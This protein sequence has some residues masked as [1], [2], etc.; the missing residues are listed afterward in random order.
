M[1]MMMND[2]TDH[3]TNAATDDNNNDN[4]TQMTHHQQ[5]L[6]TQTQLENI[7]QEIKSTQPLTS[8]LLPIHVLLQQYCG[9][10]ITMNSDNENNGMTRSGGDDDDHAIVIMQQQQQ[11]Q[12]QK[13][14]LHPGFAKAA[15]Y[16]STKYKSLRKVRGDG[17]CYYRAFLYSLCEHLLRSLLIRNDNHHHHHHH[18][19]HAEFTRLKEFVHKSL[20]WVCQYGYDEYTID[21]FWEELVELFNFIEGAT[22]TTSTTTSTTGSCELGDENNDDDDDDGKPK[23][24][25]TSRNVRFE[26]AMHQL[27]SKLNEENAT[28]DYCTWFMRVMAA[29]QMKSNPDRYLPYVMAENYYDIATFCCKEVEPMG[30]ECGMV[31]VS[32]LAEC[33]GVR[34]RIE[35][36]DGRM[37]GGSGGVD[38]GRE[39]ATHVFGEGDNGN[40][41]ITAA[42]NNVDRTTITLLYRPGHYD[43]LYRQ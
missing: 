13:Q 27:H 35:Y 5:H 9:G 32:A 25:T 40:D 4:T 19:H 42:N 21:M 17:N 8:H 3:A 2:E 22:T 39:V 1:M 26:N 28:S 10:G 6:L 23:R 20:K 15:T 38:E 36:M 14:Q 11:Q 16:L 29:A 18:H 34:V 30:R 33:M 24:G 12:Q 7:E 31:Q 41:D 43:I 37:T